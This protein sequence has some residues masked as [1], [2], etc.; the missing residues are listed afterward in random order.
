M[1]HHWVNHWDEPYHNRL[2]RGAP[3]GFPQTD[4]QTKLS[5]HRCFHCEELNFETHRV[6][7]VVVAKPQLF[8]LRRGG[9]FLRLQSTSVSAIPDAAAAAAVRGRFCRWTG[10]THRKQRP[11][12]K[13]RG[14]SAILS[15]SFGS[16]HYCT[17]LVM[18]RTAAAAVG[19]NFVI[20]FDA[21]PHERSGPD[22]SHP[23]VVLHHAGLTHQD[24]HTHIQHKCR[25]IRLS[26]N[27][28]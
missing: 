28:C 27:Y 14:I 22:Q 8:F 20:L 16:G 2:P 1:Q 25:D 5:L 10:Q 26:S 17:S 11:R 18:H 3:S 23:W 9:R 7:S 13:V 12:G 15:H 21:A 24:T 4:R 6:F 19:N